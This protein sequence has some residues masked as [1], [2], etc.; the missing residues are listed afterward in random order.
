MAEFPATVTH[1][2]A[3]AVDRFGDPSFATPVLLNAR[4][5]RREE[6]VLDASGEERKSNTRFFFSV[7]V[8]TGDYLAEGDQT[9]N[10][11]PTLAAGAMRV[12]SLRAIPNIRNT[13][14]LFTAFV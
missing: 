11:D 3:G 2:A 14:T 7:A 10:A 4:V 6:T 8:A 1:W 12:I 13:E 5:E 9:G